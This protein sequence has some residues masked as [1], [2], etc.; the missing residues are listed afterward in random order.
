METILQVIAVWFVISIPVSLIVGKVLA[1]RSR[2]LTAEHE[3]FYTVD[4][5]YDDAA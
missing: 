2:E 1:H 3:H 5:Q 4:S